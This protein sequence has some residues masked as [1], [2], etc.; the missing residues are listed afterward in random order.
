MQLTGAQWGTFLIANMYKHMLEIDW[1]NVS[2]L[3]ESGRR[4]KCRSAY[5]FGHVVNN[6]AYSDKGL[7]K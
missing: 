2:M 7:D 6:E 3:A 5:Y 1:N 4:D